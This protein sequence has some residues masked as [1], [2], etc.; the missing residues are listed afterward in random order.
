[1][2]NELKS[3]REAFEAWYRVT[4][5][6]SDWEAWQAAYEAGVKA[7]RKRAAR[8]AA[9]DALTAESERLGLYDT[10]PR[11]VSHPMFLEQSAE[12]EKEGE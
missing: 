4:Y 1:M 9:L 11:Y 2:T 8:N 12:R 6:C 3:C 7:E 5:G 10:P